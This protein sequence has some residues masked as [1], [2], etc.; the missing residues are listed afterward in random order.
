MGPK[1]D[2]QLGT[3][4]FMS[5]K[6]RSIWSKEKF[7]ILR[8][9]VFRDPFPRFFFIDNYRDGVHTHSTRKYTVLSIIQY[10]S[11]NRNNRNINACDYNCSFALSTID[12]FPSEILQMVHQSI[13][14][15]LLENT[16]RYK[17]SPDKIILRG[18]L[19]SVV[20]EIASLPPGMMH[21]IYSFV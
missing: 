15:R 6:F 16:C 1:M 21:D 2:Q 8:L 18:S 14:D 3:N 9:Y 7:T 11:D 10:F 4:L 19:K 5:P 17:C 20:E 13:S 12:R